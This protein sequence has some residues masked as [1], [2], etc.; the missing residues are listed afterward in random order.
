M[1]ATT[2]KVETV[3]F[4]ASAFGIF[5]G[6]DGSWDFHDGE[7]CSGCCCLCVVVA[8]GA[9]GFFAVDAFEAAYVAFDDGVGIK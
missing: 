7:E 9:E 2:I 8:D 5:G 3:G 6:A 4:G 1:E